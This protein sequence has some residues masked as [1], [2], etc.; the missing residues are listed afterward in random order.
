MIN[1]YSYLNDSTLHLIR[2]AWVEIP[3]VTPAFVQYMKLLLILAGLALREWAIIKPG[4]FFSRTVQLEAEHEVITNG[5][6]RWI[7]H[8]SYTGML[9]LYLGIALVIG[10]WLGVFG[11]L[12]MMLGAVMYRISIEETMLFKASGSTIQEYSKRTWRLFPGW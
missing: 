9:L 2:Q 5:P 7:R 3:L 6:Y 1:T 4:R 11:T 8:P 10:T 12:V